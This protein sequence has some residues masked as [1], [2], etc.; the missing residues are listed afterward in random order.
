MDGDG[1]SQSKMD[2]FGGPPK[3]G[4][5]H[6]SWFDLT[7][8]TKIWFHRSTNSRTPGPFQFRSQELEGSLKHLPIRSPMFGRLNGESLSLRNALASQLVSESMF[9]VMWI[10]LVG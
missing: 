8:P 9:H 5:L 6:I 7:F 3:L 1:K 4:N 10:Y 2:D